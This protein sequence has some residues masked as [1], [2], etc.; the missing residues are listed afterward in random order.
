MTDD[1]G[2]GEANKAVETFHCEQREGKGPL[3]IGLEVGVYS[4][5]LARN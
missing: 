1:G 5:G 3:W 2:N 4:E